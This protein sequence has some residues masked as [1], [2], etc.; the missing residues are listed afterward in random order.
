MTAK[1]AA[2]ALGNMDTA[3]EHAL[4]CRILP[5]RRQQASLL[6]RQVLQRQDSQQSGQAQLQGQEPR[7]VLACQGRLLRQS[8]IAGTHAAERAERHL[9]RDGLSE[10]HRPAVRLSGSMI[11][12]RP[13]TRV[14]PLRSGRN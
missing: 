5:R 14:S 8:L 1:L 2:V 7:Q 4:L 12:P 11:T 13:P 10:H 9:R 6:Q 3:R